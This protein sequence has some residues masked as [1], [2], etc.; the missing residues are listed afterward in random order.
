MSTNNKPILGMSDQ[1]GSILRKRNYLSCV[2]ANVVRSRGYE[3]LEVPLI[4][5]STSFSEDIVGESPW[6]EWDKRGCF[7]LRINDYQE[8]FDNIQ[9]QTDALLIPEGTVSVSRWLGKII[10]NFPNRVF[11]LKIFYELTCFRNELVNTLSETK[12]RQFRQFGC[13]ILGA[14]NLAADTETITLIAEMLTEVGVPL[15]NIVV[16]ISDVRLFARLVQHSN[17]SHKDSIVL[18]EAMDTVAECRAGKG[19]ERRSAC[20]QRYWNTLASYQLSAPLVEC[21]KTI[22]NHESG[23]VDSQIRAVFSNEFTD[24]LDYF[25]LLAR[26]IQSFGINICIDLC[27]VRSHEYYTGLVFELDVSSEAGVFVEI[28]GGGRYDKLVANFVNVVAPHFIPST[29][30]AFGVERVISMLDSIGSF[31]DSKS[32]NST[33]SF[34]S[35][36]ADVLVVTSRASNPVS[37]YLKALYSIQSHDIKSQRF[38]IYVGDENNYFTIAK[39]MQERNIKLKQ[40]I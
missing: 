4:E 23:E 30:F 39:Y 37:D 16:R 36:S 40:N 22:L 13:E 7:Y 14:S 9:T 29:G 28:A 20:E 24:V 25:S 26:E 6:P 38:D 3:Q 27:V 17:I 21:W 31:S 12:C 5:R 18:K 32:V 34:E 10:D 15:K 33:I 35:S 11:P 2:F 8:S 1:F 19:A